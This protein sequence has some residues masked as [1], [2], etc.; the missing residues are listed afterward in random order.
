MRLSYT[1]GSPEDKLPILLNGK[2][3]DV[4]HYL[5]A[6]LIHLRRKYI[7]RHNQVL[8]VAADFSGVV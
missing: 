4:T 5:H 7:L 8:L 1:W 6:A 3:F 2:Q